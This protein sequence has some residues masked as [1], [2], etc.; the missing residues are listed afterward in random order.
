MHT[1]N[2]LQ[3]IVLQMKRVVYQALKICE[4]SSSNVNYQ[5]CYMI[6]LIDF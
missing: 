5:I 2:I 6:C 3:T 4:M 1:K